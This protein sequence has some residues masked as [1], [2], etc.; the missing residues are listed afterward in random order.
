MC[1]TEKSLGE[2]TSMYHQWLSLG[3]GIMNNLYTHLFKLQNYIG[4]FKKIW[5]MQKSLGRKMKILC[6]LNTHFQIIFNIWDF[7][8]VTFLSLTMNICYNI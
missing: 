5:K 6:N 7:F 4:S 2:T 3:I 8:I 1:D